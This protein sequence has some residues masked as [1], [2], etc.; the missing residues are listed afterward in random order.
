MGTAR[1]AVVAK[2]ELFLM[3]MFLKKVALILL[4]FTVKLQIAM[5]KQL[6][7]DGANGLHVD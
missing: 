7:I 1:K 6:K 4:L 5:Q 3:E 2:Q